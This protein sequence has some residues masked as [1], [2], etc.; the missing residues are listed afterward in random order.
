MSCLR[1]I[2]GY[3]LGF[4]ACSVVLLV[5]LLVDFFGVVV[6]GFL[7]VLDGFFLVVEVLIVVGL[8]IDAFGVLNVVYDN[9]ATAETEVTPITV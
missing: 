9:H 8:G 5:V 4:F 6:R 3:F 2:N 1:I 7:A